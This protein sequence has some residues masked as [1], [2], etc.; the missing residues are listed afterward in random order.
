M[1]KLIT[2]L[3]LILIMC[4]AQ[5]AFSEVKHSLDLGLWT[6]HFDRDVEPNECT[7]EEHGLVAY[8]YNGY[9]GG[10]YLNSHCNTSYLLTKRWETGIS[11]LTVDTSLVS[12][13][14]K[15]MHVLLGL[16]VVPAFSYTKQ[17]GKIGITTIFIPGVLIG[18]GFNLQFTG[19]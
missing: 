12:G 11:G 18:T 4:S 2:A 19:I 10:T 9:G 13:Y 15:S 14:P 6:Y 1:K 7:N 16:V 8:R 5:P 17:I 3:M